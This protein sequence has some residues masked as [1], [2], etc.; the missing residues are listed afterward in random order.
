MAGELGAPDVFGA[1]RLVKVSQQRQPKGGSGAGHRW[2]GL[3]RLL[4]WPGGRGTRS[5]PPRPLERSVRA[6][7]RER[8]RGRPLPALAA[9]P[10]PGRQVPSAGAAQVRRLGRARPRRLSEPRR[11]VSGQQGDP[12]SG[13]ATAGGGSRVNFG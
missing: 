11:F 1:V 6:P 8:L 4:A 9:V 5:S 13:A 12:R 7:A 10:R 2:Q 3:K